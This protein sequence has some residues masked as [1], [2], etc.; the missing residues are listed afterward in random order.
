[1]IKYDYLVIATGSKPFIP[2]IEGTNLEGVY[3]LTG[4]E[5][6]ER[7]EAAMN[8]NRPGNALI[9]G[10]GLI[11]LQTAVA[12]SKK[13][14]K[15]TVVETLPHLLPTIL[16]ADMTSIVQK[17][18]HKEVTFIFGKPVSAIKGNQQVSAVIV[19]EE[20]I[21]ADIVLISAGMRPN[22]DIAMK[23]GIETGESRGIVTDRSLR[24][25]KG[26]SYLNN[27]YALGDCVE[28]LDAV[29]SRPRLSQLASTALI[30]ARVVANNILG[31]SSFYEPCLSPTVA[32]ISGLQVGSVGV[33]SETARKY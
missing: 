12:F 33:L 13:G 25:K 28:V 9:I 7:I 20:E 17:W 21:S 5:D 32:A 2:P 6:G 30:Q 15:T 23:A 3:T 31:I 22:V 29:T 27:V 1:D 16:D 18:L 8:A 26:K 14:I 24:V 10:A 11:G 19:G 4:K